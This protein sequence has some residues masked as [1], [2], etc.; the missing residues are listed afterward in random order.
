MAEDNKEFILK[1]LEDLRPGEMS[2][3]GVILNVKKIQGCEILSS[4]LENLDANKA[5]ALFIS[6]YEKPLEALKHSLDDI[7]RKDLTQK[8]SAKFE[9]GKLSD[10]CV[11]PNE[12]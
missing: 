2:K 12:T 11:F 5:T 3:L 8:I 9:A 6:H 1:I 10:V 7:P 4:K